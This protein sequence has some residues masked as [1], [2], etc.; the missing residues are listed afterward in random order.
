MKKS[1]KSSKKNLVSAEIRKKVMD[2]LPILVSV[3]A[4]IFLFAFIKSEFLLASGFVLIIVANLLVKYHK[5]EFAL[6]LIGMLLGLFL[7]LIGDL[8]FKVQFWANG[9]IFGL[10]AWLPLMWGFG[11]I[12]IRRLGNVIVEDK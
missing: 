9:S 1:K 8:L 3:I 5:G 4:G 10:P 7:E 6:L 12:A 11:F 2:M